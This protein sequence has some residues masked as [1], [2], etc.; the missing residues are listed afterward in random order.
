MSP[1]PIS[2]TAIRTPQLP[3]DFGKIHQRVQA[4]YRARGGMMRMP[5]NDW[6]KAELELKPKL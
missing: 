4:I 6:L 1:Q 5:L 2:A 3:Q